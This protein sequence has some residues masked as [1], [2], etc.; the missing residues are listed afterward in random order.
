M[1]EEKHQNGLNNLDAISDY[2][3]KY[4]EF[5]RIPVLPEN[6]GTLEEQAIQQHRNDALNGL[7]ALGLVT[8]L[9]LAK[10]PK[11]AMAAAT[12]LFYPGILNNTISQPSFQG[13]VARLVGDNTAR[14]IL[15][16]NYQT[17]GQAFFDITDL[18]AQFQPW[19]WGPATAID[20]VQAFVPELE[21]NNTLNSMKKAYGEF[22]ITQP[23]RTVLDI[24]AGTMKGRREKDY[25]KRKWE[26]YKQLM[27]VSPWYEK[28]PMTAL[29]LGDLGFR[30]FYKDHLED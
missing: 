1:S 18:G 23:I 9:S 19:S 20:T 8:G 11:I 2:L 29:A 21:H 7:G 16:Q 22:S 24:D 30:A 26:D 5:M 12:G 25:Y 27:R 14:A 4:N 10:K 6:Q 3:G 13:D 17:P 28:L 15:T